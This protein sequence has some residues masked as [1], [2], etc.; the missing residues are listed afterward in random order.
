L[1]D[2]RIGTFGSGRTS[3][4]ERPDRPLSAPWMFWMS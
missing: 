1:I 3:G 2:E 4:T